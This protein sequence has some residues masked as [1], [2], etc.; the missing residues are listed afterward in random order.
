MLD[1]VQ[2]NRVP[3]PADILGSSLAILGSHLHKYADADAMHDCF[4]VCAAAFDCTGFVDYSEQRTCAFKRQGGRVRKD[5]G[6][7]STVYVRI[8]APP[9]PPP[10]LPP[11]VPLAPNTNSHR[12]YA[13]PNFISATEASALRRFGTECLQRGAAPPN[14]PLRVSVG[15]RGCEAGAAAVLL[16]EVE[17]RIAAL[18]GVP[19]HEDEEPLMLFKLE[20]A[21]DRWFGNLHQLRARAVECTPPSSRLACLPPHAARASVRSDKNKQE[22]RVATVLVYLTSLRQREGGHTLF[23]ALRR[24]ATAAA[25]AATGRLARQR[26]GGA[27]AVEATPGSEEDEDE[28]EDEEIDGYAQAARAAFADGRRALGCADGEPGCGDAG[29]L[30][31]RAEA[32]CAAARRGAA[33]GLA[34]RPQRGTALFFFSVLPSGAADG[35]MW[36][37]GCYPRSEG[38]VGRW[39]L[40]KFKSLP[41]QRGARPKDET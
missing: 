25:C 5:T 38:K 3:G 15:G 1:D 28:D 8:R 18:T 41:R 6:S 35:A 40:Q 2:F 19:T 7:T 26:R 22:R 31:A 33:R 32:E 23:P 20:A 13:V 39:A 17:D 36:H 14:D 30:V 34:V 4:A 9:P 11:A 29:G 21:S 27:G 37:T 10:P 24:P 16:A 12:I